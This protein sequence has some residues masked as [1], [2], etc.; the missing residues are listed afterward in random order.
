VRDQD[1]TYAVD[2]PLDFGWLYRTAAHDAGPAGTSMG[3]RYAIE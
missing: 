3:C 2:F 1:D